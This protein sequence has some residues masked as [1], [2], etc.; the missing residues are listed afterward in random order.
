MGFQVQYDDNNL[1][2]V[3]VDGFFEA[4]TYTLG[5]GTYWIYRYR[6]QY[7]EFATSVPKYVK[8][9][10]REVYRKFARK[11]LAEATEKG[12]AIIDINFFAHPIGFNAYTTPP[13]I[14]N[15]RNYMKEGDNGTRDP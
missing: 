13:S 5:R 1:Y 7:G 6:D 2:A 11:M 10:N 3:R 9:F 8:Q 4:E 15:Y 14:P 12:K